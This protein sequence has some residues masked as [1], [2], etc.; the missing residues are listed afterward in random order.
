[1]YWISYGLESSSLVDRLLPSGRFGNS[2][3]EVTFLGPWKWLLA[4]LL[5]VQ[6]LVFSE[7]VVVSLSD[8]TPFSH[9]SYIQPFIFFVLFADHISGS[10]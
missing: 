8:L 10:T 9:S 4:F 7:E 6:N 2:F 3:V 1:L 5:L